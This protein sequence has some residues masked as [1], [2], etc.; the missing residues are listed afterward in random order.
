MSSCACAL[1]KDSF[2]AG[3]ASIAS[4]TMAKGTWEIL[5]KYLIHKYPC[6]TFMRLDRKMWPLPVDPIFPNYDRVVGYSTMQEG[7]DSIGGSVVSGE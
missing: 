3:N 2:G 4:K 6:I 5:K 1:T 7:S